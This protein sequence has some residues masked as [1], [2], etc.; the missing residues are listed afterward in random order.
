MCNR[1]ALQP[2]MS[3]TFRFAFSLPLM[4][5]WFSRLQLELSVQKVRAAQD[6][7]RMQQRES[8]ARDLTCPITG[9]LL[10]DP[11]VATD[12]HTYERAAIERWLADH[13]TSPLTNAPLACKQLVPNLRLRAIAEEAKKADMARKVGTDMLLAPGSD[14]RT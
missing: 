5:P 12:G 4:Q 2:T 6:M 9:E 8:L 13:Q 7:R 11:V 14:S 10:K 3:P 1:S